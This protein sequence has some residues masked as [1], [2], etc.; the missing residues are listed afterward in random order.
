MPARRPLLVLVAL[1]MAAPIAAYAAGRD[2][3]VGS[4]TVTVTPDE[5]AARTEKEFKDTLTFK[6][7]QFTAEKFNKQHGIKPAEYTEDTRSGL[8]ATFKCEAKS[9]TGDGTVVWTG[10]S[11]GGQLKGELTWT[12]KDGTVVKY[13][14]TGEKKS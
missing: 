11:T 8:A 5:D 14:F 3:F 1:L 2:A 7:M 6:G 4:W 13:S 9:E 12:K 10:Q